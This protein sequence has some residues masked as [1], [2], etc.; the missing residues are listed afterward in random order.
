MEA[1]RTLTARLTNDRWMSTLHRVRPPIVD[2]TIQRRHSAAYFH[3][4]N[5]DAV[6]STLPNHLDADNGPVLIRD[7]IKAE[8]AGSRRGR[9]STAAVREAARVLAAANDGSA[10]DQV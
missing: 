8:L 1:V 4:G 5:I 2:G 10:M 6:I 3:N 9:A 7:H